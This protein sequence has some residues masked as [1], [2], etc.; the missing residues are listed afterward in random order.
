M[1]TLGARPAEIDL[2][3]TDRGLRLGNTFAISTAARLRSVDAS[4]LANP[5]ND[6]GDRNFAIGLHSG[7][8]DLL[9]EAHITRRRRGAQ[10]NAAAQS[11]VLADSVLSSDLTSGS[12][13]SK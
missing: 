12:S 8:F 10:R 1:A 7:R 9:T 11:S 6:D 3:Q 5:S 2:G 4:L 13:C